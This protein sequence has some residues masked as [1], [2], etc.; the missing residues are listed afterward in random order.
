[1]SAPRVAEGAG[2]AGVASDGRT[3]A[4]RV[5]PWHVACINWSHVGA[6]HAVAYY[7]DGGSI[8]YSRYFGEW[9]DAIEW[10]QRTARRFAK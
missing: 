4:R 8:T 7:I 9:S 5:S 2:V 6:P 10:A 1:M 3:G